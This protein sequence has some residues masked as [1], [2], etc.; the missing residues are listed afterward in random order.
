MQDIQN[1]EMGVNIKYN[2]TDPVSVIKLSLSGKVKNTEKQYYPFKCFLL[3]LTSG[4]R[5][6]VKKM[7]DH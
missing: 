1:R 2:L 3:A 4:I 5:V 7:Y 6:I